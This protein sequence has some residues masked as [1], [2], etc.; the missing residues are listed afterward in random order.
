MSLLTELINN[1][2][3]EELREQYQERVEIVQ[4]KIKFMDRVPVACLDAMNRPVVE[5]NNLL[6]AAG[7]DVKED[8][9]QAR[10]L[11]YYAKELGMIQMMGTVAGLLAPTWPS[12][13]YNNVY[14]WEELPV[15]A[16]NGA[17]AVDALEDLVEMLYPGY[18]VFGNEGQTWVSFKTQ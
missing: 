2:A 4:H 3:D 5:L 6:E 14:I 18:F 17:A 1:I 11:I 7:G 15:A 13:E 12:V 8:P 16:F 10:V 9:L